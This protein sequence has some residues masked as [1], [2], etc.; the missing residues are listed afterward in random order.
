MPRATQPCVYDK[1]ALPA[2]V[3]PIVEAAR[4]A[5][6]AVAPDAAE[7]PCQSKRPRS[8]S[9]MWKLARY[10]V[11][12]EVVVTIGTFTK[13]S[14]MFFARGADVDDGSGLLQGT[15]KK[16]RYITLRTP[17]DAGGSA[18]KAILREAF[19]LVESSGAE[20]RG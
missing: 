15:G 14:S 6:L 10:A 9:M 19:A 20:T 8:P 1:L 12:G 17:A 4:R 2:E 7:I 18:V 3:R 11:H 16:L 13:H 5:V